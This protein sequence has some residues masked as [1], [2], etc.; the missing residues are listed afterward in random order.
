[1]P[2]IFEVC[3]IS[4]HSLR[5]TPS[6]R[7]EK[8]L[9]P[10]LWSGVKWTLSLPAWLCAESFREF[11]RISYHSSAFSCLPGIVQA[12]RNCVCLVCGH[13]ARVRRWAIIT[14]RES[15]TRRPTPTPAVATTTTTAGKEVNNR[16]QVRTNTRDRIVR[17]NT[18]TQNEKQSSRR[19]KQQGETAAYFTLYCC[20]LSTGVHPNQYVT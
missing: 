7:I 19:E 9:S 8:R 6:H 4:Y 13:G 15:S 2:Y 16:I 10:T 11:C 18:H 20:C 5:Q 12:A 3:N 1:M 17:E 14:I